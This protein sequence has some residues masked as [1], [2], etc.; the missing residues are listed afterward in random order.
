[1][2]IDYSP[3]FPDY[4]AFTRFALKRQFGRFIYLPLLLLA[5]Y[6][7]QPL[8]P[9]RLRPGQNLSALEVYRKNAKTLIF[10]GLFGLVFV[11]AYVGARN[12]WSQV[13][14][15]REPKVFELDDAQLKASGESFT[16]SVD[17]SLVKEAHFTRKFVYLMTAQNQYYFFPVA[18]V[19]DVDQLRTL[20]AAKVARVKSA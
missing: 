6:L 3:T 14:E 7:V 12:R 8:L 11:M 15:L 1:M 5:V 10:P 20:V 2:R 4:W 16:G 9:L 19:P 18:A 17:W 13:K